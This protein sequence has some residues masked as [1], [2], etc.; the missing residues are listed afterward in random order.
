MAKTLLNAINEVLKRV[1]LISENSLLTSLTDSGKQ[2][3]IDPAIQAWGEAVD[4]IYSKAR[5]KRP[6]SAEEDSITLVANK[7]T[8]SLASDLVQLSWPLHEETQGLFINKY[9]GGYEELRHVLT[10][11]GNYTGQPTSGAISPIDGDLFIDML[12]T[13]TEAGY[14]YKYTYWRDL[15]LSRSSDQFPFSDTVFRAMVPV[16]TEIWRLMKNNRSNEEIAKVNYGRAVRALKQQ[17][18]DA[19]WITRYGATQITNP[20]GKDPYSYGNN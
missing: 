8:Y 3:F 1:H 20:L 7:R 4:Q 12:P 5:I 14:I 2:G 19:S 13:S 18:R 11:P 6:N 15:T 17:P 16:V 9:P 10:Q